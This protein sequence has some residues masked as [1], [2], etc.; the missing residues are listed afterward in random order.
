[1]KNL[2]I[3]EYRRQFPREEDPVN[4]QPPI[5]RELDAILHELP[6]EAL[7]TALRGP[8][9]R[10]PRGYDTLLLWRCFIA[11]YLLGLTSVAELCRN[12]EDNPYIAAAV[13]VEHASAIPSASTFCRFGR[14]LA[15][16]HFTLLLKN[17]MREMVRICYRRL[18]N[19]GESVSV[20]ASDFKAWS[21]GA[22]KGKRGKVSDPDAGWCVKK[23][24]QGQLK[25]VWGFKIHLLVDSNYELPVAVDVSPGNLHDSRK[26][27]PLLSQARY[28]Y[29][30]FNPKYVLAGAAYCSDPIRRVIKKQYGAVALIDPNP[31]H[32]RAY[33]RERRLMDSE[34]RAIYRTRQSV[35]R[36]FSRL[37]SHRRLNN[38]RCRGR[39]QGTGSRHVVGHCV[40]RS[41]TR[42]PSPDAALRSFSTLMLY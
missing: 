42:F 36:T 40:A 5:V 22:K 30:R 24:T 17:V 27:T 14:K 28:T 1:M 23:G 32:R 12:L 41:R 33:Q 38:L 21:N 6:D 20:D 19:F 15:R 2:T 34:W 18:P 39:A 3:A 11:Y 7:L 26:M 31:T 29:G 13:G 10:G 9:R 8:K 16:P 25:Y 35:E 37:K 4:Y